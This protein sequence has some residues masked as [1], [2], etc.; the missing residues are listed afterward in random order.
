MGTD[1]HDVLLLVVLKEKES[2]ACISVFLETSVVMDCE[3]DRIPNC[4]SV[5]PHKP[6]LLVSL[7]VLLCWYGRKY[8]EKDLAYNLIYT[9]FPNSEIDG[10]YSTHTKPDFY[11]YSSLLS[12]E[13]G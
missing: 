4:V 10:Q 5:L 7:C 8:A 3:E 2:W 1:L 11:T 13:N 9:I 12:T 6:F